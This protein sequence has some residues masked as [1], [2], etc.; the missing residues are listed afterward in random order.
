MKTFKISEKSPTPLLYDFNI[1][2]N[3]LEEN[4]ITL[5]KTNQY[6]RG[7]DLFK[8]NQLMTNPIEDVTTR[9][10]QETYPQLHL[11]YNL[12]LAGKLYEKE[13]KGKTKILLKSTDLLEKYQYLTMTE[14]YFFL[15]E[16]FW[17]DA[18]WRVLQGGTF[19][20]A[21]VYTVTPVMEF[22][23]QQ[24]AGQKI[25]I[26]DTK[27][28]QIRQMMWDWEYY[29]LYFEIFGF[30]RVLIDEA[31]RKQ[32]SSRRATFAEM[33]IPTEFGIKMAKVLKE[34]RD[35]ERWNLSYR[36][37]MGEWNVVP[38]SPLG[39]IDH[40][41][42]DELMRTFGEEKIRNILEK[43][44]IEETKVEVWEEEKFFKPFQD[45]FVKG[46]LQKTISKKRSKDFVEGNYIFKVSLKRGLWRRIKI[47]ST[48]TLLD[49]HQIIQNAF[50]F[51][52]DHLYAF[53]M[54]GQPWSK[55]K[56]T[57]PQDY[58]GI[59]V[60]EVKI[61]ELG[62]KKGQEILYL[63]DYGDEWR[64]SVKLEKINTKEELVESEIIDEKGDAPEQY[65]DFFDSG[66]E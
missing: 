20:K 57:H 53:F 10:P 37:A 50:D 2:I 46:E 66:W 58:D 3:Y 64:F 7:K 33:L 65:P 19:G 30:W 38:G 47:S 60:T 35:L 32:M 44:E 52:D 48:N 43:K 17:I 49:L 63:F 62:L 16:T 61:G 59:P 8:L 9:T 1:F 39:E 18:D 40:D 23:S 28:G 29:L 14:K 56:F 31:T 34:E 54:S 13:F 12:I 6:L 42:I 11:F 27:H 25:D 21:D 41:P 4:Q 26:Q 55:P 5:T 24:S 45:L 15:L 51:D 36:E 22:L